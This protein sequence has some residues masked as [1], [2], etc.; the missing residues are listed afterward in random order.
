MRD[1]TGGPSPLQHML[2]LLT[3]T[4]SACAVVL[5]SSFRHSKGPRGTTVEDA[6]YC[7]KTGEEKRH[8]TLHNVLVVPN[9][10]RCSKFR[11]V[12]C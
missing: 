12:A 2:R 8:P 6:P 11:A 4:R 1:S 9:G 5:A 7:F 3:M 10:K